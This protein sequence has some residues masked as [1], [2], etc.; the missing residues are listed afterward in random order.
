VRHPFLIVSESQQ[1]VCQYK[2]QRFL[3]L[4]IKGA[5]TNNKEPLKL[6]NFGDYLLAGGSNFIVIWDTKNSKDQQQYFLP[7]RDLVQVKCHPSLN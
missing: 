2:P 7:S 5:N 6:H 1:L 3:N 4:E